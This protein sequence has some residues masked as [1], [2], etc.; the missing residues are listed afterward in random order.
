MLSYELVGSHYRRSG[1]VH[2]FFPWTGLLMVWLEPLSWERLA[3]TVEVYL[4]QH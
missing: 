1:L 3:V 2:V 4:T